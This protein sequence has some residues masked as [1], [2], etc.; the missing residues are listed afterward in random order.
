[1]ADDPVMIEVALHELVSKGANPHVPYGPEEVAADA[2][3]CVTAGLTLLH[4]HAR[5]PQTGEQRWHDDGLYTD[6]IERV[7]RSGASPE[8]PWYPTYPGVRPGVPVHESMA[9]LVPLA[10]GGLRIAA[11]DL[12]SFNLSAYNPATREIVNPSSVKVLPH[13]LFEEFSGFCR[14]HGLRPYLGV[15]EPGHLRHVATYLDKGWVEPPLMLKF[16]FSQ[17]H[18]YGL[19]P[20]PRCLEM[21]VELL[22]MIL[23]GV[24][25]AWFV[26]CYGP[27]IW[28]LAAPA[29][30]LGGHV[31]VGL[32]DFHPWEWPA[33]G[34]DQ[35]TNAEMVARAAEL[36]TTSGRRVATVAEARALLG[37]D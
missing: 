5:D 16:F 7:R 25:R 4:F 37:L 10:R 35:P 2:C 17:Y 1:V 23:P 14:S 9:H 21:Q 12:G 31:R 33:P 27:A 13:S 15:Y 22:D 29:L 28:S 36:A 18:P 24:E 20:E 3:A 19:P 26:Q 32:G 8:L 34:A 11:I 30:A 6:S